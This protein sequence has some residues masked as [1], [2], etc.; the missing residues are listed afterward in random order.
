[1]QD[2]ANLDLSTL[3]MI[4][5]MDLPGLT[6][7]MPSQ[8]SAP[9]ITSPFTSSPFTS[10]PVSW[11]SSPYVDSVGEASP[12]PLQHDVVSFPQQQHMTKPLTLHPLRFSKYN[13]E[14]SPSQEP[15]FTT[16]LFKNSHFN[17]AH[18]S[19]DDFQPEMYSPESEEPPKLKNGTRRKSP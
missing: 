19:N 6:M 13:Y 8:A 18:F 16:T 5:G 3:A 1:M 15:A 2:Y 4:P 12:T 11:V 14:G 10:S 17:K 7:M 9:T